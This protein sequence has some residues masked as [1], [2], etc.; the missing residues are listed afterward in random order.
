MTLAVERICAILSKWV[1]AR[2]ICCSEASKQRAE[3]LGFATDR[4]QVIPN[5]FD[6]SRFR[7]DALARGVV[8]EE[9]GL[10][11]DVPLVG[12]VAR[13]DPAKDHATFL[14]AAARVRDRLP[15]TCFVL[16]GNG[17]DAGNTFLQTQIDS[18]GLR[19]CVFLLGRRS[20]M[21]RIQAALDVACSSSITEGFP[22]VIGEAMACGVPCVVTDVGDSAEIVGGTGRIVPPRDPVALGDAVGDLLEARATSNEAV[23]CRIE[24]KYEST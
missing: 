23:R 21:P 10:S 14:K 1:P 19:G 8:R 16:C 13:F 24:A 18:L 20:D 15:N 9:L 4:L 11:P 5:G 2:V 3:S 12:L 22:N 6:M 7:P 17:V